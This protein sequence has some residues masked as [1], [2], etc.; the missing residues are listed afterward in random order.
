MTK[1]EGGEQ[2]GNGNRG[3]SHVSHSLGI[4]SR[5]SVGLIEQILQVGHLPGDE[6]QGLL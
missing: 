6:L 5:T 4:V 1:V 2:V 3:G